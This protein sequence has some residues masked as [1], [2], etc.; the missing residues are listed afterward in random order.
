MSSWLSI[1][2]KH[3]KEWVR[4]VKSFG[5]KVYHEDIVQEMYLR[6]YKY[7]KPEDIIKN[8]QVNK[9]YIW[10]TLR[11]IYISSC[12]E[13]QKIRK[14]NIDEFEQCDNY[15]DLDKFL[16]Y[17]EILSNIENEIET[18]NWYDKQLFY[19]YHN[20]NDS[21]RTL[22]KKMGIS[23]DSIH[24]TLKKCNTKIRANVGEDYEDYLNKDYELINKKNGKEN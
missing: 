14:V 17:D 24:N 2:S 16:T 4:I 22:S 3:H 15:S 21:I 20:S 23:K 9:T 6:I 10:L 1:I 7:K 12:N 8:N 19:I 11:N 13:K 5:E 18:W